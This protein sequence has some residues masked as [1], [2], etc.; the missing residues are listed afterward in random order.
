MIPVLLTT[1]NRLEY[2]KKALEALVKSDCGQI[3]LIDNNST[4]GTQE[5]IKTL[6]IPRLTVIW[7]GENLGVRGAM[8]QFFELT[9]D[10]EWVGK[11]DN[12]T[13]VPEKWAEK[14]KQC[15]IK[16]KLDIVQAKHHIIPA[17]HRQGW[18]GFVTNL[19]KL[20]AGVYLNSFVGGSGVIVRRKVVQEPLPQ[21]DWVLGGWF[22]WQSHHPEVHKGFSEAV[23]IKLLDDHGYSDYPEYYKETKRL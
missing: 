2:T 15:A 17:T 14:L 1:Y 16:N 3:Y 20:A 7:N 21:T 8:N 5:W 9:K 23:E 4:D 22:D 6:N 13:I 18:E 11:V 19:P 12:D 10:E